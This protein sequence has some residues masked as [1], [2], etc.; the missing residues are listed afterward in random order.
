[1]RLSGAIV[2]LVVVHGLAGCGGSP[3]SLPSAPTSAPQPVGPNPNAPVY[4]LSR[5]TLSGVVSEVT[6]TG[7]TPIEG[8][9]VECDDCG[10]SG[11]TWA[12]TD[13][14]GLYSFTGVWVSSGIRTLLWVSKE[15]YQ[16]PA[17]APAPPGLSGPGW[18]EVTING[19]TQ[20]DIQLVRR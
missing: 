1:M 2:L 13:A 4:T 7:Q 20:F 8:V 6:P 14:D 19:D 9:T 11:H 18:R 3:S 12:H 5:V 17:G 16:D 15:G 10:E